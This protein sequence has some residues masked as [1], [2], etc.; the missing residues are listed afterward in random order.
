MK[1][2]IPKGHLQHYEHPGFIQMRVNYLSYNN[3]QMKMLKVCLECS[4]L[5]SRRII[6]IMNSILFKYFNCKIYSVP[7]V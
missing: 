5:Q 1:H 6:K 2:P 3:Y 7:F 4:Y